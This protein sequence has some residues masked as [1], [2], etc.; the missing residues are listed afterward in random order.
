VV[1]LVR[2]L[3]SK[4]GFEDEVLIKLI[5]SRAWTGCFAIIS[6]EIRTFFRL[7]VRERMCPYMKEL[8]DIDI[9]VTITITINYNGAY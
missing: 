2:I 1:V 8:F 4:S 3:M 7:I 6:L 9:I 5:N